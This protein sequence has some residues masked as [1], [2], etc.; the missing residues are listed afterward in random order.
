M[1]PQEWHHS[2]PAAPPAWH[3]SL[4]AA[5]PAR[6]RS[7][8]PARRVI[9][10]IRILRSY[11]HTAAWHCAT[12]PRHLPG[13]EASRP[14]HLPGIE[15][16]S[17]PSL[18]H[19]EV[20]IPISLSHRDQNSDF[21]FLPEK[22]TSAKGPGVT[23]SSQHNS[24]SVFSHHSHAQPSIMAWAQDCPTQSWRGHRTWR[25]HRIAP[26][27]YKLVMESARL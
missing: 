22:P 27:H 2:H 1:L 15:A 10:I 25:G 14:R 17:L 21:A 20:G 26:V 19:T 12:L 8:T 11:G 3:R 5:P 24:R 13:I 6:H 9:R 4:P 18:H 7:H 23:L 16:S